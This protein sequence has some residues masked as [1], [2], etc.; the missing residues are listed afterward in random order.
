[1]IPTAQIVQLAQVLG[2]F[3][4]GLSVLIIIYAGFKYVTSM[5]DP[6]VT[7]QAKMQ[8]VYSGIGIFLAM[9]STIMVK[10]FTKINAAS[11]SSKK[12]VVHE[13]PV[14]SGNPN[15]IGLFIITAVIIGLFTLAFHF[16]KKK[17]TEDT[18]VEKEKI[19]MEEPPSLTLSTMK[20]FLDKHQSEDEI[21][22]KFSS[23]LA[24]LS[25]LKEKLAHLD[26]ETKYKVEQ[27]MEADISR[28]F[29]TYQSVNQHNKTD[30]EKRV[31]ESLSNL[32][33]EMND[34]FENIETRNLIQL[35]KAMKIIEERYKN[36]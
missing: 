5:G 18:I 7:E 16:T 21:F 10:I 36:A 31:L 15:F 24:S 27:S 30:Y 4:L 2:G 28:L 34:I 11:T 3:V 13:P 23:S 29:S 20:E 33:S 12:V 22:H 8:I 25:L 14:E 35:E 32:E 26:L 17:L 6:R 19:S 1:M 9:S